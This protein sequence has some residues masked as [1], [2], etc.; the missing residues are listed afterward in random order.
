PDGLLPPRLTHAA[1]DSLN[2]SWSPPAHSNAPG[3]LHYSLQMRTSPQRPVIRLVENATDTYSYHVKGLL[4]FTQYLFR[5]VVS[6]THGQTAGP[7][8]TLHTAE[9]SPGPVVSPTVS[10][11]HPRSV[12]VTWV[13]PLQPNGIITNYT[14]R[15]WPSS[16]SSL[17]FKPSSISRTTV[18]SSLS[19]ISGLLSSTEGAGV[20]SFKSLGPTSS[21]TSP[22]SN[23][24]STSTFNSGIN[25]S[26]SPIQGT[27]PKIVPKPSS[28][29]MPVPA[30]DG[31]IKSSYLS[32]TS[33]ATESGTTNVNQR[34]G[35]LLQSP[36]YNATSSNTEVT[37]PGN[38]TSFTF[39]DLLPYHTYS[40]Q[41]EACT[42]VGCSVSGMSQHFRTLPAPPEGVPAPHLYSD[43]PTSVLLSWGAPEQ[44]NGPLDRWLIERRVTGTKPIS[45]VGQL[46]PESPPL[47]FLDSSSAL[48][49]WTSYQYRLV[50]HN[51]AGNT[52]GPWVSTTTRPSRPAG[53]NPPRLKVLGP[54]SFQITWS[55]PLIP[56][57]EIRGY[58]IRLPE[59]RIFH[60]SGNTSELSV[61]VTDLIP[62][63]NYS[64]TVLACSEGDG[65]VG[66][67][68]ESL[69][70]PATTL[71][72]SPQ[73]LATL[74]VVAVS[75]SFLAISWQPP[76]RPNGPNIRYKLLRRK[77]HQPL[78]IATVPA[79]TS[80][81]PPPAEDLH[82]WLH[83]YSGTKLF[84]QDKGLSRFTRYEYQSVVHNDVGFSSG[85]VVTAVTMAGVPLHPP[86]LS[87][88]AINHTAVQVN[89]TQPSLQD[90]QGAVE[91]YFLTVE[92]P[93]SSQILALPPG[94]NSTVIIDLW[95]SSTYLVSLQVSNGAHNTT[96]AIANVTTEDG[97]PEG[98]SAPE[99]V[100]VDSATVRVLWS[101][102]LRPNGAV[103]SYYIYVNDRLRGSVDNSSGSY[104][105]G[106]LLPYTV[107]NVQV[108]VCTVYACVRSN[109]TQTTTVE[110][111]PADLG[112]PH[113]QVISPRA[114]RLNWSHPG[115]PSGIMLGYKVLRRT[116][117]SC[118]SGS[119]GVMSTVGGESED[120]YCCPDHSQGRVSVG[121]GDSCCGGVPYSM[122]GGQLCCSRSLHDGYGVQCCGG[123]IVDDVPVCCGDAERGEVH[124]YVPGE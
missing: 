87:A 98:M 112:T 109:V 51:Q 26:S 47:S 101:P 37:I 66:G 116:L 28:S 117:R 71:S 96:R 124:T 93:Q 18:N 92:S 62:Y 31:H 49:P 64:I 105:L 76:R 21:L 75:E 119:A 78:A 3:P 25:G 77:T 42:S 50:L 114:V 13:P 33:Q 14:L 70:T 68:T 24:I 1:T 56:N 95:P 99:V 81:S 65:H 48:S 2:V 34:P 23:H 67:C 121:L 97:E 15:L 80:E 118:T 73:G 86:S 54:E 57:G 90:L 53:L 110:D 46:P 122:K 111:L 9:D 113:T 5:V 12:T 123:R 100:P 45:T 58:E 10:G 22:D 106:D 82:H 85:E 35:T 61:T 84:Y 55:P 27:K 108:E 43:T 91:S 102:P 32:N 79:V 20:H 41:V 104:L 36:D 60:E 63:K 39:R 72:T 120:E 115:K 6:H 30:G 44:S 11:F 19:P 59:P 16:H 89:W 8:A 83:V 17:A 38:T 29:L 94:I 88:H 103:T 40:L 52:T 74:S 7:W 69:P 107:Y 4:P